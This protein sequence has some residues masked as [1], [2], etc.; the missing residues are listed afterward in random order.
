MKLG[1][2]T[3]VQKS[4]LAL[5]G[6]DDK[7]EEEETPPPPPPGVP[8]LANRPKAV[9][10]GFTNPFQPRQAVVQTIQVKLHSIFRYTVYVSHKTCS[11]S[12]FFLPLHKDF[13]YFHE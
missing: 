1:G 4:L 6:Q 3:N 5:A 9:Q 2:R 10:P 8:P 7:E 12:S 13:R 11:V